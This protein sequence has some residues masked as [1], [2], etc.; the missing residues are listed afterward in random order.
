MP[1]TR[2]W[3]YHW[4]EDPLDEDELVASS[5]AGSSHLGLR[6]RGESM[7]GA[8]GTTDGLVECKRLASLAFGVYMLSL[9]PGGFL[10]FYI[11]GQK[12]G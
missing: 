12:W 8:T 2:N 9:L 11:N 7:V 3:T 6:M 10:F 1:H 5:E 4:K